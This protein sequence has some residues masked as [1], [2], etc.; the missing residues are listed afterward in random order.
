MNRPVIQA[1]DSAVSAG[2]VGGGGGIYEEGDKVVRE[3]KMMLEDERV[4][5]LKVMEGK[6]VSSDSMEVWDELQ[7]GITTGQEA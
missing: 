6:H 4:G 5:S 2:D 7:K 1:G 3:M